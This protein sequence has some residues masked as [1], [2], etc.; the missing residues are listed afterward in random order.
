MRPARRRARSRTS[1]RSG[2]VAVRRRG[3]RRLCRCS[4]TRRRRAARAAPSEPVIRRGGEARAQLVDQGTT[5]QIYLE[6]PSLSRRL[7]VLWNMTSGPIHISV[8]ALGQSAQLMDRFDG[9]LSLALIAYNAGP[10]STAATTRTSA[11]PATT[12]P[13]HA[14]RA[15]HGTSSLARHSARQTALDTHAGAHSARTAASYSTT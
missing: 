8:A 12:R 5:N 1:A 7:T 15:A 10:G 13:H 11:A 6:Q 14:R 2:P 4:G 3:T 9:D